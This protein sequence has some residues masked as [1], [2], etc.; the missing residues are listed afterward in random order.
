MVWSCFLMVIWALSMANQWWSQG[1]LYPAETGCICWWSCCNCGRIDH[2]YHHWTL[3]SRIVRI[4]W[5]MITVWKWLPT[6]SLWQEHRKESFW[7]EMNRFLLHS[8]TLCGRLRCQY[9]KY[10]RST[11]G[12]EQG[13]TTWPFRLI[14]R[15][16]TRP[17]CIPSSLYWSK[18]CLL[19]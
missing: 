18:Y 15:T 11:F 13:T 3:V 16:N 7:V 14:S 10:H 17:L 19:L 6:L 4:A 9:A 5:T 12:E 8:S 2:T 1:C